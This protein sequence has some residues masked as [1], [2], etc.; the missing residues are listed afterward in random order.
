MDAATKARH[1]IQLRDDT[2]GNYTPREWGLKARA[3]AMKKNSSLTARTPSEMQW[4]DED[5]VLL[6]CTLEG[7]DDKTEAGQPRTV[8]LWKRGTAV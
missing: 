6:M 3:D 1:I 7:S 2:S 8:R 4:L 5:T